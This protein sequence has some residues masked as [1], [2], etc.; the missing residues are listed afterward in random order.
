MTGIVMPVDISLVFSAFEKKIKLECGRKRQINFPHSLI[1][2]E[3]NRLLKCFTSWDHSHIF[4]SDP[5]SISV[6]D[7]SPSYCSQHTQQL[8]SWFYFYV[9]RR[10]LRELERLDSLFQ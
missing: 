2:L 5:M 4:D 6:A 10:A 7:P 9:K 8:R 1:I 3:V